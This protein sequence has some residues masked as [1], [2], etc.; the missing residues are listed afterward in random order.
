[1]IH[2][3]LYNALHEE[4][5]TYRNE[6]AV[7]QWVDAAFSEPHRE[8]FCIALAYEDNEV[9]Q[10]M[11]ERLLDPFKWTDGT[12]AQR[13]AAKSMLADIKALQKG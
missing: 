5:M 11:L 7:V 9:L 6:D 2:R 10:P 3:Q 12:L 8:A 13:E 1:M 4:L